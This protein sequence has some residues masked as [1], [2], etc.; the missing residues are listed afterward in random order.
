MKNE[1]KSLSIV[2]VLILVAVFNLFVACKKSLSPDRL[3]TADPLESI[4]GEYI[5]VVHYS[6]VYSSVWN[7]SMNSSFDTTYVFR[8]IVSK[9]HND[10]FTTNTT[11]STCVFS[12]ISTYWGFIYKPANVYRVLYYPCSSL[13]GYS[14]GG[15]LVFD[16][17]T[18]SVWYNVCYSDQ[19]GGGKIFSYTSREI[20]SGKKL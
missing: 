15:D 5:G 12:E 17:A 14:L 19:S 18:D 20:F 3:T 1:E 9:K 16:L 10:T 8:F 2:F 7:P 13:S 11:Y 4:V 6:K